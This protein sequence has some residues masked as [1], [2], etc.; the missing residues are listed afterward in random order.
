MLRYWAIA[1]TDVVQLSVGYICTPG[2]FPLCIH[3][4]EICIYE[5]R[6]CFDEFLL[7]R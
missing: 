2:N 3:N 7:R 6:H 5:Q 4:L 1:F